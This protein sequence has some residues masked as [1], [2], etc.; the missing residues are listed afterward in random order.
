MTK[1]LIIDGN[2]MAC[3]AAFAKRDLA[4]SSG[5]ETGGTSI[6]VGMI[7]SLLRKYQP[8]HMIVGW[9]VS[10]ETFR[11]SIDPGYK[12][13]R[14]SKSHNLYMQFED[15]KK[16]L[17]A[18]GI[19]YVGV[20]GYEAD[21][22]LGTYAYMSKA[23]HNMI[24]SGDKDSFQL[25]DNKTHIYYPKKGISDIEIVDENVFYE[26]FD[27]PVS[28]FIDL[29]AL[30]GDGGDNVIGVEKCGQKTAVKWL[31]EFGTLEEVVKNADSFKG[32]VGEN[33]RKWMPNSDMTKQLV[34]IRKDVPVPFN[35]EDCEIKEVNWENARSIFEELEFAKYIEKLDGG[36]FYNVK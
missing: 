26:K 19:K 22:I 34:T 12:A 24:L 30:M 20:Y 23:D 18:I 15:I 6:F 1:F 16:I 13:T 28:Q 27:I 8:T 21:D 36:K 2:S 10:R 29:K 14:D 5:R 4:T 31:K 17:D 25:I 9:D 32:K 3:R 35:F 33:L 7:D 11:T